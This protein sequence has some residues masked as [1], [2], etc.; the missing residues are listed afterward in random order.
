MIIKLLG[1][2]KFAIFSPEHQAKFQ[3]QRLVRIVIGKNFFGKDRMSEMEVKAAMAYLN[4]RIYFIAPDEDNFTFEFI[5][6]KSKELVSRYGIKSVVIDNWGAIEHDFG[7]LTETQYT[8]NALSKVHKFKNLHDLCVILVAHPTKM[9]KNDDGSFV[10][11]TLY[12][13]NGSSYF[14]NK[15]DVGITVYRNDRTQMTDVVFQKIKFENIYGKKGV[16]EMAYDIETNRYHDKNVDNSSLFGNIS[17]PDTRIQSKGKE[18][19]FIDEF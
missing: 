9:Q 3:L 18:E 11:P 7:G 2:W 5:F 17:H 1:H 15:S 4:E 19:D 14:Y 8:S 13:I 6:T 10:I 12:S 16:V